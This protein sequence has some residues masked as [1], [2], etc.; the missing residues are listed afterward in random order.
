MA[1]DVKLLRPLQELEIHVRNYKTPP[2][3]LYP[4]GPMVG[5]EV[6]IAFAHKLLN[7]LNWDFFGIL[8]QLLL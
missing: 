4:R 8:R 6:G 3:T 1:L 5:D 2:H 7:S